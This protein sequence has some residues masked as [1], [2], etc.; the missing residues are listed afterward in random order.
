MTDSSARTTFR[1]GPAICL[2]PSLWIFLSIIYLRPS[3]TDS[4]VL[5]LPLRGEGGLAVDPPHGV[6]FLPVRR[7]IGYILM[8]RVTG[9]VNVAPW[10]PFAELLAIDTTFGKVTAVLEA[11][12][13]TVTAVPNV[14]LV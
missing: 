4:V 9:I 2:A 8:V 10:Q 11:L 3:F 6:P 7:I 13:G 1:Q 5:L 12:A 14:T